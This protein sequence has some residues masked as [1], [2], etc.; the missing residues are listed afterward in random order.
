MVVP[1]KQILLEA[2]QRHQDPSIQDIDYSPEQHI[3]NTNA[4]YRNLSK[5]SKQYN[6][7]KEHLIVFGSSALGIKG[8]R[9]PND[10]DI[11]IRKE[12]IPILKQNFKPAKGS[13]GAQYDVGKLSFVHELSVPKYNGQ[14]LFDQQTQKHKGI[15]TITFDQWKEMQKHDPLQKDKRFITE[16]TESITE[17]SGPSQEWK[18][19]NSKKVIVPVTP[20]QK[21]Q[22]NIT[23]YG[24]HHFKPDEVHSIRAQIIKNKPDIIVH[25]IPEDFEFYN[26]HLPNTRL[27]QLERGL[28]Q[29]IYKY[30][31][32]DLASQFKHRETNML[33]NIDY[34]GFGHNEPKTINVVVG[35]THLRT[36]D[37]P[38]LGK[39]SPFHNRGYNI[40]RSKYSEIK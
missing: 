20:I 35:D 32:N 16:C 10:L 13:Y 29:N 34:A 37:T 21:P 40:V 25:E 11:G 39:A 36:I 17:S 8:L 22:H 33:R 5:I 18:D 2:I 24:E 15:N 14:S 23:V 12:S 26:K 3:Q 28:D 27:Y 9:T 38:E 7:P 1:I 31:P 30:F 19:T 4:L 6:I